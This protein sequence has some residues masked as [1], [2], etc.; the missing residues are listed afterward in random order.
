MTRGEDGR[1]RATVKAE[2]DKLSLAVKNSE[3]S[4]TTVVDWEIR[5]PTSGD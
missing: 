1:F 3:K 4:Y 5:E 2:G